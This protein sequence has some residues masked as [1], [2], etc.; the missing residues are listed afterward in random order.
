MK[1]LLVLALVLSACAVTI[2]T[3]ALEVSPPIVPSE[4]ALDKPVNVGLQ[5]SG[6]SNNTEIVFVVLQYKVGSRWINIEEPSEILL[7]S[8]E[9][10]PLD[11][12][13]GNYTLR[14]VLW[15][16]KPELGSEADKVSSEVNIQVI[17]N[18][19]QVEQIATAFNQRLI[20]DENASKV[21]QRCQTSND[22]AE[23]MIQFSTLFQD[24]IWAANDV[25]DIG[26]ITRL[27]S[28]LQP[29]FS[30]VMYFHNI[31]LTKLETAYTNHCLDGIKTSSAVATCLRK[32]QSNDISAAR[33]SLNQSLRVF[34]RLLEAASY[35]TFAYSSTKGLFG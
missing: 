35:E 10:I 34:N 23:C 22:I 28:D 13:P 21:L 3:S 9:Q 30:S 8:T 12:E 31:V 5:I 26:A 33:K 20:A 7:N 27:T 17:D 14:T 29:Q 1:R 24:F 6:D 25:K 2:D 32:L 18:V 19:T 11:L 16:L 4:I 15:G